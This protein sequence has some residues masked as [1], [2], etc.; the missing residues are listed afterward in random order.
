MV[1]TTS[2]QPWFGPFGPGLLSGGALRQVGVEV[3]RVEVVVLE[4][5]GVLRE[6]G[7]AGRGEDVRREAH[8]VVVDGVVVEPDGVAVGPRVAERAVAHVAVAELGAVAALIGRHGLAEVGAGAGIEAPSR[9]LPQASQFSISEWSATKVSRPYSPGVGRLEAVEVRAVGLDHV[10]V[11]LPGVTDLEVVED[12]AVGAVGA[13]ADVLDR[14]DRRAVAG[15]GVAG[16]DRDVIGRDAGALDLQ[17]AAD[18]RSGVRDD[19]AVE[20]RRLRDRGVGQRRG[21]GPRSGSGRLGS[22]TGRRRR[23]RPPGS[24]RW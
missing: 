22:G 23:P 21:R 9:R 20:L 6:A 11:V 15:G 14:A 3:V 24:C 19:V 10:D 8:R 4:Q 7:V 16:V 12:E 13:D 1:G 17:V 2:E 18:A 5:V